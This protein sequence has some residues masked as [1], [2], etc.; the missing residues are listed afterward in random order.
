[1]TADHAGAG[2]IISEPSDANPPIGLISALT[3]A[4]HATMFVSYGTAGYHRSQ[5]HSGTEVRIAADGPGGEAVRG[6]LDQTDLFRVIERAMAAF[7]RD[8]SR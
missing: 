2:Q 4:D 5:G 8:K 3:T 7:T 6:I 1:V